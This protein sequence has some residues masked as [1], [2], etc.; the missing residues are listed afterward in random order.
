MEVVRMYHLLE[1]L[2]VDEWNRKNAFV[3]GLSAKICC[4]FEKS[5]FLVNYFK[6]RGIINIAMNKLHSSIY[7]KGKFE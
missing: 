7:K 3:S 4:M 1:V 2:E 5:I 6:G